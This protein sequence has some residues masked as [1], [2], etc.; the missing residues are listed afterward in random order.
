MNTNET[1]AINLTREA[2]AAIEGLQHSAG[3]YSYYRRTLDRLFN[4]ILHSSEDMG[5]DD[6]EALHT[7]RVIDC[8]REDLKAIA[9]PKA[10]AADPFS[11][12]EIGRVFD[13]IRDLTNGYTTEAD[14]A[15]EGGD[16]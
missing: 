13:K 2:I 14:E 15:G 3:T 11:R 6:I 8:I 9:G 10:V 5:M 16:E 1:N 4:Y 7:L 12:E